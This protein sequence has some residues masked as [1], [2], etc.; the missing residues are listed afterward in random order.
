MSA[1]VT[2]IIIPA[3]ARISPNEPAVNATTDMLDVVEKK[4][5][6]CAIDGQQMMR[7]IMDWKFASRRT[8]TADKPADPNRSFSAAGVHGRWRCL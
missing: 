7:Y 3:V 4:P 1:W 5:G 8:A 2:W 6:M